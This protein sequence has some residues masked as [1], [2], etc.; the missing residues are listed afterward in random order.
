MLDELRRYDSA[1]MLCRASSLLHGPHYDVRRI[2]YLA[3]GAWE[4]YVYA[5]VMRM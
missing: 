4:D 5:G 2:A 1:T 3:G